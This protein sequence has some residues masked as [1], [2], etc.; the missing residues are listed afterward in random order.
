MALPMFSRD[1]IIPVISRQDCGYF[2]GQSKETHKCTTR[3][4]KASSCWMMAAQGG[5]FP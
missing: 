1:R 4:R 2:P 3:K 5:T